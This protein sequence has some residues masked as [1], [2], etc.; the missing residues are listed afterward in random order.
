MSEAYFA[1]LMGGQVAVLIANA[2]ARIRKCECVII[3]G[4]DEHQKSFLKLP[5]NVKKIEIVGMSTVHRDLSFIETP[6]ASE[7]RCREADI[8]RGLDLAQKRGN[9]LVLDETAEEVPEAPRPR[10]GLVVVENVNDV[11]AV[12]AVNYANAVG[13]SVSVVKPLEEDG[14]HR[15]RERIEAWK[16]RDDVSQYMSVETTVLERISPP[17]LTGL[18]YV[19]FFTEGIPYS[20]IL[21]NEVPCTYVHL[22][23]RPDLFVFNN[24]LL[25]DGS[26]NFQSVVV[27][28][29]S[30]FADEET[31]WLCQFFEKNHYYLRALIGEDATVLN[32]DFHS[33]YFPYDVLH[34]CSHGGEVEGYELSATFIDRDGKSH[35][36]DFDEVV[37]FTPVPDDQDRV[38]VH[39]KMFPRKLDG[40]AW[41][42]SALKGQNIPSH[43]YNDL[44]KC[45]RDADGVRTPK[46]NVAM[47]CSIACADSIHQG[48]FHS[49]AS[50]STPLVFNNSCW[51]WSEVASFFL[52]CGVK[53]Y[54]GTL[55]GIGNDDA[56]VAAKTFYAGVFDRP[57]V[58]SVQ[59][60][61]KSI[62]GTNSENIYIYWGLHFT[63][64]SRGEPTKNPTVAIRDELILAVDRWIRCIESTNSPE[65]EKNAIESLKSIVRE[66]VTNFGSGS[67]QKLENEIVTRLGSLAKKRGTRL[68]EDFESPETQA[69][70]DQPIE[71][72]V[73]KS[74]G[75]SNR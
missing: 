26:E 49:L 30:F 13:A 75:A 60:A 47:S 62:D 59:A 69:Y 67:L 9:R 5:P 27:F 48:S 64:I 44:W 25:V 37:G 73:R 41:K 22:S 6:P 36:I 21:K 65:I 68:R 39:R 45:M 40:F 55:W 35:V 63:K 10:S 24:I 32:F 50:C 29:P 23:L 3:A 2:I 33:Q 57:V 12:V 11:G 74:P 71:L 70:V 56:V 58:D 43:V 14:D 20:L 31:Q 8:L 19:T 54:I 4:L 46:G 66:L 72:R 28:S 7:L 15:I 34:I 51:S 53:G 17:L 42:S 18:D 16:S 1:E 52:A 38:R 61:L